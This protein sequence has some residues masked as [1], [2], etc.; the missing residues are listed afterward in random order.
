MNRLACCLLLISVF[1]AEAAKAQSFDPLCTGTAIG[2]LIGSI[3][4]PRADVIELINKNCGRNLPA[5]A[6]S[7]TPSYSSDYEIRRQRLRQRQIERN[8][9]INND[10]LRDSNCLA[11]SSGCTFI[12]KN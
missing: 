12:E 5:N 6:P 2:A 11:S 1:A 9:E 7:S 10:S 4:N 3:L 8:A